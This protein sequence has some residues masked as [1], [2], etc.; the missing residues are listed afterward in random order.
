ML[1]AMQALLPEKMDPY[2]PMMV[3]ALAAL[4]ILIV[5]WL[6]SKWVRHLMIKMLST[7]KVDRALALF[8]SSIVQYLVLAAA[9]I[10][11][12]GRVGVESTS[13]VAILGA[14]GLAVGF[15]LQGSLGNFASGVMMLLFRP[16]DIGQRVKIAGHTGV[17]E[18]IG[19]F[20]T[21]MGTVD[22][23][24][25]IIP[26][27]KITDDSIINYTI[28]GKCRANVE[29]G[30]AYGTDLQQAMEA[31]SAACSKADLVLDEPAPSVAFANFGAS[32]LDL[33]ARPWSLPD[34]FPAMQHNVRIAIYNE[35]AA[36]DIEIPFSQIVVHQ[37]DDNA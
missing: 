33:L 29:I 35:L 8:L 5:G 10:T 20:A 18:E 3:G 30:V 11:A 19:L 27:A 2:A 1:E 26:N 21:T 15:A 25:I 16:I 13:F 14:A 31:I 24:T 34:H 37:A 7:R 12:L 28:K 4:L 9:V 17:V 32:S 23:E 6:A 36:R 22:N